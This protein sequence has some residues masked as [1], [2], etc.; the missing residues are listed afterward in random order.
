M[1]NIPVILSVDVKRI[2]KFR[3][4][5]AGDADNLIVA[6][7]ILTD[8]PESKSKT[9]TAFYQTTRA[10]CFDLPPTDEIWI[11]FDVYFNG[12]RRWRAYNGGNNGVTGITAQLSGDLSFFSNGSNVQQ[13]KGICTPNTLQTVLLHMISGSTAGIMEAWVDGEKIYTYTGDVNHGQDF[14]DIY[15]QS[16]GAGTFFSNVVISNTEIHLGEGWLD[17]SLDTEVSIQKSVKV[18]FAVQRKAVFVE[19]IV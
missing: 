4:F 18:T 17:L 11:K 12:S 19:P 9:G 13:P 10:K 15:L 14:N 6:S 7:T 2:L 3:Y 16:D 5:N 8:L 1:S